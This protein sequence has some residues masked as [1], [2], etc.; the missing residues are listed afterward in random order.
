MEAIRIGLLNLTNYR[1]YSSLELTFHNSV[2][3]MTG[4]NGAGKTS[5][6]D[7]IYYLCNGK[8]YFTHLDRHI[9]KD[10]IDH[11]LIK[12]ALYR[13]SDVFEI[14]IASGSKVKK[15]IKIEDKKID[16]ILG[17]LGEFPAFI[18]APKDIQ[19]L[20]ESSLERRKVMDRT[21]SINDR[22]YLSQLLIYNKL[23]KQRNA[24]LKSVKDINKVDKHFLNAVSEKMLEP[25]SYISLKRKEYIEQIFPVIQEIYG[26]LCDQKELIEVSYL[27][28][29]ES[30]SLVELFERDFKKDIY[31]KKTNSGIHKDDLEVSLDGKPIK[32]YASQGQIKSAVIS[33]KLAQ[34]EWIKRQKKKVPIL[35]LD[36]IFDK[37]DEHRVI[38]LIKYCSD[39]EQAQIFIT[40]TDKNRVTS[41]LKKLG[42]SY[43]CY[44]IE[45]G[46]L[47]ETI[48]E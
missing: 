27:T 47:S 23:L 7:A 40:D 24:Y 28:A 3:V 14:K 18:I 13:D 8:S 1:N 10:G 37:L 34:I 38:R 48:N 12:G 9:Y 4:I 11:F 19:I 29:L 15:T 46:K 42:L 2:N 16:S 44:I 31:T 33:L 45:E 26:G 6:L 17:L 30:T 25:A 35:L 43:N 22:T 36:D 5:I 20:M 32:K 21:I 39:Q 41:S